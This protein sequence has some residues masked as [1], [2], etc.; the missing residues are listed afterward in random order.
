MKRRLSLLV[1]IAAAAPAFAQ[2]P[3]AYVRPYWWDKPVVEGLGRAQMDVQPN[4]ARFDL[5]FVET[6]QQ[7]DAAT[8]KAVARAKIAYDAIKKVA[9]DKAR[10]TTSVNVVAFYEQYRDKDGNIQTNTREDK[11]KGYEATASMA[12]VLT[13][14][15]LAGRARAAALALGPQES[16]RISIY[17]EQTAEMQRGI[18]DEA[19]KDARQRASLIATA[20]GGRLGDVLVA[21]E[22]SDSCL[23]SWSSSQVARVLGND[24]YRYRP[25]PAMAPPPPPPMPAPPPVASGMVGSRT[26]TITEKDLAALDLP[27]DPQPQQIQGSVCVIYTLVK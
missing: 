23:G 22:G 25:S 19:A 11:V 20:L 15:S 13:D 10:V 18:I 4:R 8:K 14:A 2:E 21:Q 6:D 12:V 9:G 1:F 27:S 7:S 16:G 24:D 3:T 26:V 17:L 5:G